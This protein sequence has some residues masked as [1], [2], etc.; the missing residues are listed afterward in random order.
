MVVK[1]I[2]FN[3]ESGRLILSDDNN[4]HYIC[5]IY[6]K[7]KP[8]FLPDIT[9]CLNN[10]ERIEKF[11]ETSNLGVL[12][13]K[14]HDDFLSHQEKN[15]LPSKRK[16]EGYFKFPS[17]LSAPFTNSDISS[18]EKK[19]LIEILKKYFKNEKTLKQFNIPETENKGISYFTYPLIKEYSKQDRDNLIQLIDKHFQEYREK[20]KYQLNLMAKDPTIKSLRIFRRVLEDNEDVKVINGRRLPSPSDEIKQK[21]EILDKILTKKKN[22]LNESRQNLSQVKKINLNKMNKLSQSSNFG[23]NKKTTQKISNTCGNIYSLPNEDL[24]YLSVESES[25]RKYTEINKHQIKGMNLLRLSLDKE[26]KLIDGYVE[27]P[28]K[29]EGI[30]RKPGNVRFKTSAELYLK[31]MELLEKGKCSNLI[32][33]NFNFIEIKFLFFP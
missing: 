1:Q 32:G 22:N 14:P 11:K 9:G 2:I 33:I 31:D 20:N 7:Q 25:E 16:F 10:K 30:I 5:D 3:E 19:K 23:E 13:E 24:S 29:E 18:D 12:A 27:K 26:C 15:Y 8:C 28:K 21:F 4:N 17:P 6:G